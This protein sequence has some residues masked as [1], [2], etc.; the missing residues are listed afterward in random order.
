MSDFVHRIIAGLRKRVDAEELL[1][2]EERD[3]L[4]RANAEAFAELELAV[5]RALDPPEQQRILP[6]RAMPPALSRNP[7]QKRLA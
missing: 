7:N 5:K 4:A 6:V 3:G 2:R 1:T